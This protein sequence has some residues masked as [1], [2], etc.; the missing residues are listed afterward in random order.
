MEG[1]GR[2][3]IRTRGDAE[4]MVVTVSDSGPGMDEQFVRERL[5]RPFASTKRRGLGLGL[6]Q[7]RAIVEAH[8]G[9]LRVDARSGRG[10]TFSLVFPASACAPS[11]T[12]HVAAGGGS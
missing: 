12:R 7:S 1:H 4:G 3:E 8:G 11:E 5:F 6:Y 10:C 2:L 9:E